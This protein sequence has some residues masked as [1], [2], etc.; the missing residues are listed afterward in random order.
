MP[1]LSP[2]GR[3]QDLRPC[4]GECRVSL[5]HLR[6]HQLYDWSTATESG[7]EQLFTLHVWS[8]AQGQGGN[9]GDHGA[10]RELL[11]DAA[12]DARRQHQ[13]VNLRL[14]FAEARF[15]EDH[16]RLSRTA[17]VS[18]AVSTRGPYRA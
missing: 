15:D 2:A 17:A 11:H 10:A 13:L 7:T 9:A 18:A 4:A 8:K 1:R 6:A 3:Q 5:H 14:E 12:L 16:S